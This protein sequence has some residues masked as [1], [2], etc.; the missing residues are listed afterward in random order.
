MRYILLLII[1]LFSFDS[2]SDF[3]I[4]YVAST[5][6]N[7]IELKI[8]NSKLTFTDSENS[9]EK[10]L[11]KSELKRIYKSLNKID[12]KSIH[13]LTV[14][15]SKS[16]FDGAMAANISIDY[17][18]LKNESV[19]F[20]HGNPPKELKELTEYIFQLIYTDSN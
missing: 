10:T 19:T 16:H 7:S 13:T 15:S 5:R 14:P 4:S 8:I 17:K 3:S 18:G 11:T 1:S 9:F 12:L 6:G 20:D 2:N